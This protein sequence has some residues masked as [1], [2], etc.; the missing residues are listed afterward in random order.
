MPSNVISRK[1]AREAL[2]ALIDTAF[3]S[4]WDVFNYK[5][6]QFGG[7]ARNIVVTSAGSRRTI[8]GAQAVESDSGFRFRVFV[9]VLFS[10]QPITATNSPTAGANKT[11]NIPDTANFINGNTVR[12]E[13]DTNSEN[14][15]INAVPVANTSIR[16]ATLVNGYTLP[17]VYAWTP[18]NSDDE[19]DAAE[20]KIADV[21]NDNQKNGSLWDKLYLEGESDP[22]MIVD[23]GGQTFRREIITIRADNYS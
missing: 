19:I 3:S 23:E 17:R 15:V 13:D 18:Q 5:V 8:T 20:K 14:A 11:I 12:V 6:K 21:C 4:D 9:F 10:V 16:V 22:D 7:K 2:A 1:T